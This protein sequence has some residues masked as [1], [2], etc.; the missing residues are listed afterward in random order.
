M[1]PY[2]FKFRW[3]YKC[4][5]VDDKQWYDDNR[6]KS[7]QGYFPWREKN[8]DALPGWWK[9]CTTGERLFFK[10]KQLKI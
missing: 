9:T 1:K 8:D 6:F 2:L 3:L 7:A 5:N 10:S 4:S